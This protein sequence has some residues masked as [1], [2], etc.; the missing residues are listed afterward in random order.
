MKYYK[1]IAE[2]INSLDVR[3]GLVR[4]ATLVNALI[5]YFLEDSPKFDV[6]KFNSA[7]YERKQSIKP[8]EEDSDAWAKA[9]N[10]LKLYQEALAKEA[11]SAFQEACGAEDRSNR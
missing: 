8:N 3:C 11:E 7:C 5:S 9:R 2:V 10:A 6:F 4:K 1:G